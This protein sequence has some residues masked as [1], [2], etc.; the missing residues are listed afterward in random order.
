M[1]KTYRLSVVLL[2]AAVMFALSDSRSAFSQ[3]F[4]GGGSDQGSSEKKKDK[5]EDDKKEKKSR[6]DQG[7]QGSQVQGGSQGNN[8]SSQ[9][10]SNKNQGGNQ[11]KKGNN[12]S[13][14]NQDGNQGANQNDNQNADKNNDANKPR[15]FS[16]GAGKAGSSN[17]AN[18]SGN[19]NVPSQLQPFIQGGRNQNDKD[20][21]KNKTK[22]DK[23]RR[24]GDN[25]GQD[26][27]GQGGRFFNP[28]RDGNSGNKLNPGV[29][30]GPDGAGN[31]VPSN[32]KFG[33]WRGDRWEG[34]RKADHWSEVF[35]GK[36]RLFS[37][38]WYKDHP[39][40]WKYNNDK[41]NVWVVATVP[42]IYS[43][44]G[45][46]AVP[47]QYVVGYG[48][49]ARF[50][51]SL[52][53][54]WYPLGVYSL[55][56]GGEDMGTRIVQ[57]AVDRH[58]HIAGNYFDMITNDDKSVSGEIDRQTQR[59]TFW[60]NRNPNV[61]FHTSVYRLLQQP[62]GSITVHLPGAEQRWQFV[63]LEN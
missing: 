51:A 62:Y 44:L 30:I 12:Q 49:T 56:S 31:A 37:S 7:N 42:G 60:L 45:W 28:G 41:S 33:S 6:R 59:V 54:D 15:N 13:G 20:N 19:S 8:Q 48:P 63:R 27:Q 10:T 14:N 18:N 2:S 34:S 4:R 17:N 29:V 5:D 9:N 57:L 46:G 24:D 21:D 25:Q 26:F 47:Q 32:R 22:K 50:D 3:R 55:M 16:R 35:G 36:Q 11:N 52:Y 53:G 58:G 43:W 39:Q 40:A 38:Q 1:S 23:D 61:H